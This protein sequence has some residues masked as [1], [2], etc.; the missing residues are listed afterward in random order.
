MVLIMVF[1]VLLVDG[2]NVCEH[3]DLEHLCSAPKD[4]RSGVQAQVCNKTRKSERV[5]FVT[6]LANAVRFVTRLANAE[7]VGSGVHERNSERG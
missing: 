3:G 4:S 6:R 1:G 2:F 5:R 7:R